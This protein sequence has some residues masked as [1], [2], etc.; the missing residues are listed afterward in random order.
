VY[1]ALACRAFTITPNMGGSDRNYSMFRHKEHLMYYED[2]PV[3]ALNYVETTTHSTKSGNYTTFELNSEGKRIA[4][5]GYREVISIH[6]LDQRLTEILGQRLY[7]SEKSVD[8]RRFGT[9]RKFSSRV[10]AK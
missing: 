10:I 2:S 9:R 3:D 5:N 7:D 8:N 4:E 1:E 6:R